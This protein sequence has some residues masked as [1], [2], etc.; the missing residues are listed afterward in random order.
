MM[1]EY[2]H[3]RNEVVTNIRKYSARLL[4]TENKS[5]Y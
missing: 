5:R 4:Q 3:V 1:A 2:K